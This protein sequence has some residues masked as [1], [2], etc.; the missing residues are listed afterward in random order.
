MSAVITIIIIILASFF[1]WKIIWH[2]SF[3]RAFIAIPIKVEVATIKVVVDIIL[4]R[5][6]S[7]IIPVPVFLTI[8]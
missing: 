3:V 1:V 7:T 8:R 2:S 5:V 4:T 6:I